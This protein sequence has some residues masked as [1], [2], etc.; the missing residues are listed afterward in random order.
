[1]EEVVNGTAAAYGAKGKLIRSCP[2]SSKESRE[3]S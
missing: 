2:F 3:I 1:M